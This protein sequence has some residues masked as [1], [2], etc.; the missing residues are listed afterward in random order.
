MPK[1]VVF[2]LMPIGT[3]DSLPGTP[4]DFSVSWPITDY[5]VDAVRVTID[6]SQ[7]YSSEE[8]DSIQLRG[9]VAQTQSV[10]E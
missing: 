5:S 3:D 1:P 8:I 6:T 10:R 4:V 7:T 9:V 2:N